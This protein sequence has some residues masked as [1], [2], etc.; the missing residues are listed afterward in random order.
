MRYKLIVIALAFCLCATFA[1]ARQG[2]KK[3]GG[4]AKAGQ[5]QPAA[6]PKQADKTAAPKDANKPAP[7]APQKAASD[8]QWALLVG[9]S[10]YPGQIQS[11]T[12]PR[13]DARAI[14]DMLV[15]DARFRE[16]H[17]KLLTDDGQGDQKATKQNIY[18]AI[19]QY[20]A[21]RV[22]PNHQIIVFLAGHGIVRGLG[23]QAKSYFLPVDVDAQTKDS[24]ERTG[25][26][27]EELARKLSA[28][29]AA[30]FTLF[31]DACREDPFPGRG[32]K[33]NTMTDVMTRSLR[34]VPKEAQ[35]GGAALPT[36]IVF[37]ACQVGERAYEDP[38]LEHGVFTYFILNGIRDLAR[39][40]DGRVEA[41]QLASYLR[42]NVQ[43]WATEFQARAK[44]AAEQTPTMTA[45]E[46]RG[47]MFVVRLAQ[48]S[49]K[50]PAPPGAGAV[51]VITSPKD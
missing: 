47:P 22:Q 30:Q 48:I 34:V 18:A 17:I 27:L 42:D 44:F 20:L 4:K 33:G 40:P 6:A 51:S 13:N 7:S 37:Y 29:K 49:S 38:K 45:T 43:K 19:D 46:V 16:D 23:A 21:G 10:Q 15:K 31:I 9:I 1:A 39:N 24:L 32:I 41:G 35:A 5:Q 11:L 36:S 14:K 50:A 12:F 25:L 8:D 28:L 26:D 2:Q 3:S